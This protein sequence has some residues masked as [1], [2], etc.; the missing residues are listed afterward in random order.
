MKT[1]GQVID[2]RERLL[3]AAGRFGTKHS[4]KFVQSTCTPEQVHYLA[5]GALAFANSV[6]ELREL[7]DNLDRL[8]E[9]LEQEVSR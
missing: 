4:F 7:P 3:N 9:S 5:L 6:L 8:I 1:Q 2:L